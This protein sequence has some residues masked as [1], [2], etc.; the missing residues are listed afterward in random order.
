MLIRYKNDYLITGI[1]FQFSE[2]IA[3]CLAYIIT[4]VMGYR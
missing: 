2:V 1:S 3:L 4:V